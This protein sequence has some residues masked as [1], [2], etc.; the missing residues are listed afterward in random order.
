RGDDRVG[1][2]A[3]AVGEH[4]RIRLEP[5]DGGDDLHTSAA[6]GADDADVEDRCRARGYERR[7]DS[8]SRAGETV[9]GEVRDREPPLRDGDRVDPIR[10]KVADGDADELRGDTSRRAP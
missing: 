3:R 6:N 1:G 5:L 7:T 8:V 2:H 9:R 10:R 4:H